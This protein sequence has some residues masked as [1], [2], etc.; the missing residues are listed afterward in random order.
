MIPQ[1]PRG[2]PGAALWIAC[3][4]LAAAPAAAFLPAPGFSPQELS[5]FG[6]RWEAAAL[7]LRPDLPATPAAREDEARRQLIADALR[8]ARGAYAQALSADRAWL[9][10]QPL[11]P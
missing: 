3:V 11:W 6:E 2:T 8:L 9:G 7:R 4:G 10:A 1:W 5:R